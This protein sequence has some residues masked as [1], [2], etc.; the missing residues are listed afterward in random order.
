MLNV[1]SKQDTAEQLVTAVKGF[2]GKG[3]QRLRQRITK[4]DVG[5]ELKRSLI[6]VLNKKTDEA[7]QRELDAFRMV[8]PENPLDAKI[9]ELE[10]KRFEDLTAYVEKVESSN[11]AGLVQGLDAFMD[12]D[13]D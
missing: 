5:I 6:K 9:K 13:A 4:A 10:A 8:P 11:V 12:E 3:A 1:F 7:T 2:N